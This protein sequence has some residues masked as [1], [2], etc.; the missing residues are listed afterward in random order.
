MK[1]NVYIENENNKSVKVER[2]FSETR[3]LRALL[4]ELQKG[5]LFLTPQGFLLSNSVISDLLAEIF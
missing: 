2:V 5:R 1:Q 3:T 4:L